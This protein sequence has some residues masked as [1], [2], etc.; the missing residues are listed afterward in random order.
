MQMILLDWTRMG[1]TYCLAGAVAEAGGY[2]VVRPLSGRQRNSPQR[3]VGWSPFMLEG[4]RRWEIF[5]LVKPE[6]AHS[7]P[8]HLEDHWVACL[9]PRKML[10]DP[11]CRRTILQATLAKTGEPLFGEPLTLTRAGGYLLA[12][13]GRRSLVTV[14]LPT[15]EIQF[16]GSWRTGAL[17][18]DIRVSLPLPEVGPR[19]LAVKDHFLCNKRAGQEQRC[20]RSSIF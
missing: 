15:D 3:N 18:P 7:E 13:N 14:I 1:R 11:S 16:A 9:R 19:Q 20:K 8:P 17:D 6:L 5:E 2:R 10:A 12:G 4:H